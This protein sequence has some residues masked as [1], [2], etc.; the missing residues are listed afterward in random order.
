MALAWIAALG[1]ASGSG[2]P[3]SI[4]G[5]NEAAARSHPSARVVVGAGES[6]SARF[7][8]RVRIEAR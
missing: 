4:D 6:Q 5:G 1:C 3:G 2:S 7:R 8:A